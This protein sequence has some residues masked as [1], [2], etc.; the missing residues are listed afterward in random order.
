M[1]SIVPPAAESNT[2]F[3][4][5][6]LKSHYTSQFTVWVIP[7][8]F[9]SMEQAIIT[10]QFAGIT[11]L[12]KEAVLC[13][14]WSSA[15]TFMFWENT[16]QNENTID[17]FG[18]LALLKQLLSQSPIWSTSALLRLLLRITTVF[19]EAE[20]PIII[21]LIQHLEAHKWSSSHTQSPQCWNL[22]PGT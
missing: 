16:T 15:Q 10:H 18:R 7:D 1:Q 6:G 20:L 9:G 22:M 8:R 14:H 4:S 17:S 19:Y 13:K 2:A 21:I 12:D 3:S 11:K 5:A